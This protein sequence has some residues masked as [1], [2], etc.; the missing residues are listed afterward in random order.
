M[1]SQSS[2]PASS[3]QKTAGRKEDAPI[4]ARSETYEALRMLFSRILDPAAFYRVLY[5][6]EHKS[7]FTMRNMI[8]I[9]VNP[10][11]E[12]VMRVDKNRVVGKSFSE[13]WSER[14]TVWHDLI[15]QV[16]KSG[17]YGRHEGWS[18]DTDKYFHALAFRPL[19]DVVAVIFLDMTQWKEAEK[20]LLE[21]EKL[22]VE[23][24]EELRNLA[25]Q[26]SLAGERVRRDVAGSLHARIGYSLITL[27]NNLHS[28]EALLAPDSLALAKT[29][30]AAAE[31]EDLIQ[32]TRSLTLEISSPLLYEVGLE[33]A[34]VSLADHML[35]PRSISFDFP[36]SGPS[37]QMEM[38]VRILIYQMV[39][40]LLLNVIKH[41]GATHVILRVQR[42]EKSVRVL[43]EDD[44]SGFLIDTKQHWGKWSGIGLFSI[45]ERLLSLG[46]HLRIISEQGRGCTISLIAPLV[47]GDENSDSD[48]R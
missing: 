40:E 1:T 42:G 31:V 2:E 6:T 23:Y 16:A 25:A 32:A 13:V 12:E 41:A 43:V 14:E 39:Q 7:P 28:V 30:A 27:L 24:R 9:D 48:G 37:V 46:G 10:A 3:E 29:E 19:P 44:G 11:Y 21:K 35:S 26:L 36:D 17:V 34:L 15:F 18:Y 47:T 38:D 8:Y 33:A 5:E 4:Y 20:S 22:L 45:R